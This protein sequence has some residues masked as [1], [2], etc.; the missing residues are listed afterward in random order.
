MWAG[1]E[2]TLGTL[3]EKQ[4]SFNSL[5]GNIVCKFYTETYIF[6]VLVMKFVLVNLEMILYLTT[7][8]DSSLNICILS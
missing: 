8:T 5:G 7:L 2:R 3:S 4:P 6:H 1:Y